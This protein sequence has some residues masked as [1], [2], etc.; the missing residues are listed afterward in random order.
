M[1]IRVYDLNDQQAY[2]CILLEFDLA[3]DQSMPMFYRYTISLFVYAPFDSKQASTGKAINIAGDL[4]TIIGKL[5][6]SMGYLQIMINSK[7]SEF[8]GLVDAVASVSNAASTL[9]AAFNTDVTQAVNLVVSPLNLTKQV[10]VTLESAVTNCNLLYTKKS[11]AL[12]DWA[13]LRRSIQSMYSNT[14]KLY[15]YAISRGAQTSAQTTLPVGNGLSF[16][17]GA[18]PTKVASDATYSFTGVVLYTVKAK[19]TLQ[20]IAQNKLG[21]VSLWYVIAQLNGFIGNGN[22]VV[23]N[24]IYIPV[25]TG[26]VSLDNKGFIISENVARD[27]YGTDI[28]LSGD[29]RIVITESDDVGLVSGIANVIQAVN[30][31]LNTLA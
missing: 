10:M 12:S 16:P 28:Q 18:T 6:S 21:D 3:R 27:P 8:Q 20:S 22:L 5:A 1:E 26:S 30:L 15:G 14:M 25:T 4:N 13:D 23:G 7:F 29:G 11:I 31:R 2:K 17:T 9:T 19:D 24:Q